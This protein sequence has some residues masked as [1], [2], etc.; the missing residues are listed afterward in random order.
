MIEGWSSL[1]RARSCRCISL[2]VVDD[3]CASA[4]AVDIKEGA[5]FGETQKEEEPLQCF[6]LLKKLQITS[7]RRYIRDYAVI[8]GSRYLSN[9]G[10][11]NVEKRSSEPS[12]ASSTTKH[13]LTRQKLEAAQFP[14]THPPLEK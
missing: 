1:G 13:I 6:D 12:S 3:E 9:C 11:A 2:V 8:L 7:K 10:G 4:S 14:P 5:V